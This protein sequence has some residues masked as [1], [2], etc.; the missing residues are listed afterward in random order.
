MTK[1]T[2]DN[3]DKGQPDRVKAPKEIYKAGEESPASR[4]KRKLMPPARPSRI[5]EKVI[6]KAIEEVIAQ[7]SSH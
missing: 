2:I 6:I 3:K 4:R 7:R 1:Y 5:P